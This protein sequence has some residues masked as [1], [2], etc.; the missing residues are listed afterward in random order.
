MLSIYYGIAIGL[1]LRKIKISLYKSSIKIVAGATI[2][3]QSTVVIVYF[4]KT[5]VR[6]T[7][8]NEFVKYHKNFFMHEHIISCVGSALC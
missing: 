6:A 4:S 5:V 3:T 1:Y 7:C 8:N 2:F